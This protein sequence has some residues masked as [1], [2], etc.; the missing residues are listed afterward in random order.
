MKDY[1]EIAKLCIEGKLFG[2]FVIVDTWSNNRYKY[3]VSNNIKANNSR[4]PFI[5]LNDKAK[6]PQNNEIAPFN[7]DKSQLGM[8]KIVNFYPYIVIK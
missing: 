2:T 6:P 1:N 4:F 5:L 8:F 7:N 3:V